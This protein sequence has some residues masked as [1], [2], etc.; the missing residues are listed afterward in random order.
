VVLGVKSTAQDA[1]K[2]ERESTKRM[3]NE[4]EERKKEMGEQV[5]TL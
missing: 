2:A 1:E 4:Y 5:Q 3:V